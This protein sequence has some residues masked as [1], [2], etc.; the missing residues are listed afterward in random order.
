MAI[1]I[2]LAFFIYWIPFFS[3]QL[4]L[5]FASDSPVWSSCSFT[6]YKTVT[7]MA[8]ENCAINPI[9]CLIFSSNYR[10]GL[11]RFVIG[12]YAPSRARLNGFFFIACQKTLGISCVLI[13][14]RVLYI[15]K[16]VKVMM[17][18]VFKQIGRPRITRMTE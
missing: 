7:F 5:Y 9:I 14:K 18:L 4:T 11:K 12:Q 15:T 8:Y 13:L 1:A 3:N 17:I 16:F 10:C 6:L 2:V